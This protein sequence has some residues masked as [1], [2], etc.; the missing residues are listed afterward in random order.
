MSSGGILL[1]QLSP[2]ATRDM[3]CGRAP[4]RHAAAL[5]GN[6]I[7][8]G[9]RIAAV[10]GSPRKQGEF[11]N[12]SNQLAF[13]AP[14]VSSRGFVPPPW[15]AAASGQA[16]AL[17]FPLCGGP[18]PPGTREAAAGYHPPRVLGRP[19]IDEALRQI[20]ERLEPHVITSH[21]LHVRPHAGCPLCLTLLASR[22]SALAGSPRRDLRNVTAPHVDPEVR[23]STWTKT[24]SQRVKKCQPSKT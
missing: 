7:R 6:G 16:P 9:A 12:K 11:R 13:Y 5:S 21:A 20:A 17:S 4:S 8:A 23:R 10:D 22:A 15:P 19:P 1:E 24:V 14:Y 2:A 18:V 3:S